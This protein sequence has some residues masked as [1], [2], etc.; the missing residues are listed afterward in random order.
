MAKTITRWR[1]DGLFRILA[2]TKL[3]LDHFTR[4]DLEYLFV[5]EWPP[6]ALLQWFEGMSPSDATG[7]AYS[8]PDTSVLTSA[9]PP[10]MPPGCGQ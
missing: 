2:S 4:D 9:N 10:N 1:V 5:A 7:G 3:N 6:K 8:Y